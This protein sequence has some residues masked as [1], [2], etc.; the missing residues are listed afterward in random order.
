[1]DV[2]DRIGATAG[3]GYRRKPHEH[4]RL[5][6][7]TVEERGGSDVAPV[8][9]TSEGAVRPGTPCMDG[10]LGNLWQI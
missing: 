8:S 3:A 10:S 7:G 5:L 4:W 2:T 1:M 9:V 6:T